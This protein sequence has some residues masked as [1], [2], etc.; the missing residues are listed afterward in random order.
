MTATRLDAI[1]QLRQRTRTYVEAWKRDHADDFR[2]DNWMRGFDREFSAG[3]A[4]EGML[5]IS[6][7]VEHGGAG[8]GNVAR[9]AITEELLRAGAP[10][11]AHWIGERQIGP[12]IIRHGNEEL[13]REFL[14]AIM[15]A[16]YTFCLGMSEP[17]A[18]SDLASVSTRAVETSNGWRVRGRKVWTSGAH[19]ATHIYLLARTDEGERK[20]QGL[21][22][23]VVDMNSPGISVSPI[24]DIAGQHHFNEVTFDDV[25]VPA[26][27]QLGQRGGGWRQV[28]GQ[29]AFER[30]G[31]E[32]FLSTYPVLVELIQRGPAITAA[33]TQEIG[34]LVARLAVLRQMVLQVAEL[35]DAGDVPVQQAA[36]LKLMGS[37]FEVDLIEV[38]RTAYARADVTPG[39]IFFDA[40]LASPGFGIRGGAADVL[41]EMI[42]K[43]EAR[44]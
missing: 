32:R 31:P 10:T 37:S 24:L 29:L 17:E 27:R 9:L 20:H 30:G 4:A 38:A 16:E 34:D 21:T 33:V 42:A 5:G 12:S 40:L 6:W 23:F 25:H 7:P 44:T 36:M 1:E 8:L 13:R 14:P 2:A 26:T 39:P 3:L 41:L 22:E 18:G 35:L 11:G 43:Q 19:H 15:S 28:L